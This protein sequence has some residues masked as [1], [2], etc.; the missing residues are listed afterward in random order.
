MPPSCVPAEGQ[1]TSALAQ[2]QGNAY[3]ILIQED[4]DAAKNTLLVVDGVK[5]EEEADY[6]GDSDDE[7]EEDEEFEESES[8]G[9]PA[10]ASSQGPQ[11]ENAEDDESAHGVRRTFSLFHGHEPSAEL[12]SSSRSSGDCAAG[13]F[14]RI[15]SFRR[16]ETEGNVGYDRRR[17][18]LTKVYLD[19]NL[20][21][22]IHTA[23]V[24]WWKEDIVKGDSDG[25]TWYSVSE[26]VRLAVLTWHI[27]RIAFA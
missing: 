10:Q 2:S 26:M 9:A 11:K 14:A 3:P 6:G 27:C 13:M 8:E 5:L 25:A 20:A 12:I 19:A 21:N 22:R 7:A 15:S 18:T 1:T 23:V 4:V 24:E 16:R 17:D